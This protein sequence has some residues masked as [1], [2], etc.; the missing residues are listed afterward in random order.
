VIHHLINA[1]HV[2]VVKALWSEYGVDIGKRHLYAFSQD[3]LEKLG[4]KLLLFQKHIPPL[5]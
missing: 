2:V 1:K 5:W 4:G 3:Y